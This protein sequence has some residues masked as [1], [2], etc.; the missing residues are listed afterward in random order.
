M[1][2]QSL[3]DRLRV[4]PADLRASIL[5]RPEIIAAISAANARRLR[6]QASAQI[7]DAQRDACSS[8]RIDSAIAGREPARLMPERE[9][10]SIASS[11]VS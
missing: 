2:G 1:D 9:R 7:R 8:A 3:I 11:G 10:R 6:E 4:M 5:N